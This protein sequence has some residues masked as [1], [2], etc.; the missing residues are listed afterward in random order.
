MKADIENKDMLYPHVSVDC[1][2]FGFKEEKL[3]VLLVEK[4]GS[5]EGSTNFKLPGGLI[6]ENE[7]LDD[8]AYRVLSETTGAKRIR[9][10]QFRCFGSPDRTS[11]PLDVEWLENASKLKIGRLITVAYLSLC[12]INKKIIPPVKYKSTQWFP[13]DKI[14]KHL[15][16]DHNLIIEESLKEIRDWVD[17]DPSI[18]FEFLP[19]K[20]TAY[21]L[22]RIYEVIYGKDLDVRNFHK[23]MNALT[24]VIPTGDWEE[25]VSHRAARYFKFDK[26][27]YNRQ[28]SGFNKN[29]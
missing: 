1:V 16:F 7:N 3:C 14:P 28:R 18:V 6:Y 8:A 21:Q 23:K 17:S 24:Y 11:N 19:L 5:P 4:A 29:S 15:P 12:K 13:I 25:G 27:K 9:L 22:R 26:V 2:L 20:F 10:K